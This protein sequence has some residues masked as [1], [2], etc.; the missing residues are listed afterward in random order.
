MGITTDPHDGC[1]HEIEPETGMQKCYLILPD[2]QR[3]D[4]V[5]PLRLKYRH[6]GV[7]PVYETRELTPKEHE[8]YDKYNYVLFETYPPEKGL[9]RF[10]TQAQLNSGCGNVTTMGQAIAETYAANPTFYGGT[11]CVHCHNHFPVGEHGEF[12]WL[13]GTKV[14]T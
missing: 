7:R 5:R 6:V 1:L 11:M 14:G 3:K 9:G 12:V 8:T 2:G 13:D 4:L 10:W